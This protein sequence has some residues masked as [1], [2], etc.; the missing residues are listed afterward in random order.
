MGGV[1]LHGPNQFELVRAT[2]PA[3]ACVQAWSDILDRRPAVF[4]STDELTKINQIVK[5]ERVPPIMYDRR[6]NK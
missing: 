1:E 4:L 5:I 2:I 6:I 3:N